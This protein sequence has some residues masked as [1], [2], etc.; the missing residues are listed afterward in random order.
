MNPLE[1]SSVR[2]LILS[3]A[4]IHFDDGSATSTAKRSF[5]IFVEP[6][7]RTKQ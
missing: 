2:D 1:S 5:L 6:Q 3:L 7:K 4:Q